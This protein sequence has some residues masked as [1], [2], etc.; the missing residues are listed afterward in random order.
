M[1]VGLRALKA[2]AAI[3]VI[4]SFYLCQADEPEKSKQIPDAM[5]AEMGGRSAT[6]MD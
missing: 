6:T 4:L 5:L 1:T 3:L 2:I